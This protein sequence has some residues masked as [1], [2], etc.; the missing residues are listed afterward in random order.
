VDLFDKSKAIIRRGVQN[1]VPLATAKGKK[2]LIG[3]DNLDNTYTPA[4]A[5]ALMVPELAA[6]GFTDVTYWYDSSVAADPTSL[7]LAP[8]AGTT[9]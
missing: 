6:R 2:I 5:A 9:A 3:I 1:E 8:S 7:L 4:A